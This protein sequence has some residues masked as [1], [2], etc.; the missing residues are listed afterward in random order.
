[1]PGLQPSHHWHQDTGHTRDDLNSSS[2]SLPRFFLSTEPITSS[3]TSFSLLLCFILFSCFTCGWPFFRV[4]PVVSHVFVFHR[5]L[6]IFLC[7]TFIY[8]C[9]ALRS[10]Q[11]SPR[12]MLI[13]D[14]VMDCFFFCKTIYKKP[15]CKSCPDIKPISFC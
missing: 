13:D 6:A 11:E 9:F 5:W 14:V 7:F 12:L 3:L 15:K 2:W 1:M 4:S 8:E 10:Y